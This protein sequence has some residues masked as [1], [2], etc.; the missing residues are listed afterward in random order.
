[1]SCGIYKITNKINNHSYIGQSVNIENRWVDE[2]SRAFNPNSESYTSTLSKAFRKY[3]VDNFIF[4][5]I[6]LCDQ[7]DLDDKEKY[8]IS[9]Y[10]TYYNGYNET[11]GGNGTPNL[12]VKLTKEQVEEIY[13]LLK[14][15][16][17]PQSEIAKQFNVGQDVISTINHGKS[18]YN[19]N[20]NYPI[21]NNRKEQKY[22]ID[23]GIE[24][25]SK[26]TRCNLC[27]KKRQRRVEWPTR[28]ELKDLIR[29]KSFVEIGRQYGVADN[30]IKKWCINYQLPSKKQDIKTY[31]D[32]EWELI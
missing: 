21:R 10:D 20:W 30:T 1:M 13:L 23:C 2:K 7:K 28:E 16:N 25:T 27:E 14:D 3:G 22:C 32:E 12:R 8:F 4:E 19:D 29:T 11:T 17:I 31:S 15:T 24:I 26:S 6:A 18:R 9:L 5:I